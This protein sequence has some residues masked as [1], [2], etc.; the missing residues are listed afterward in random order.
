MVMV[1]NASLNF[2]DAGPLSISVL[3]I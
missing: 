1:H 2:K 3:L